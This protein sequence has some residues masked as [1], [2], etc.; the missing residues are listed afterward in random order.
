[1]LLPSLWISRNVAYLN[2]LVHD[3]INLLYYEYWTDKQK[4]FYIFTM[5]SSFFEFSKLIL[6]NVKSVLQFHLQRQK[7]I[8]LTT[9][10][11][12][13]L[14]YLNYMFFFIFLFF[15][16]IC[17]CYINTNL[18]FKLLVLTFLYYMH[19]RKLKKICKEHI[20]LSS[21][22]QQV[23]NHI[24]SRKWFIKTVVKHFKSGALQTITNI[25]RR[26]V[27]W[28]KRIPSQVYFKEFV[29]R[30]RKAF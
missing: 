30:Y 10:W 24:V 11:V 3:M 25:T 28:K 19:I 29:Q 18:S 7:H 4:Y 8:Y 16:I 20:I 26:I 2:I 1:M 5:L 21:F 13:L 6:W 17:I 9:T 22:I 15:W 27:N 12:K 14:T 23:N